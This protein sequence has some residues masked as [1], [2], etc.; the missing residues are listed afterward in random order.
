MTRA[1]AFALLN[2]YVR[3]QSLVCHCMSVEAAMRAYAR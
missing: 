1:G 3:E 2:E